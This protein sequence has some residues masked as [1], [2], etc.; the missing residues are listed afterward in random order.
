MRRTRQLPQAYRRTRDGLIFL[1]IMTMASPAMA[2]GS[3]MP[4]EDPLQQI[5]D[6]ITGPVAK[7]AGVIAVALAGLGFAFAESG[8]LMKKVIGIVFGL[9]I[10]FSASTFF[11]TFFGFSGGAGF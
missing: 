2:G 9:C 4:W 8:G 10:A 1:A 11:L 6:S 5:A 3:G 7:I